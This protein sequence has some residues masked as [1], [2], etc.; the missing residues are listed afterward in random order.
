MDQLADMRVFVRAI[1]R[2]AFALAAKDLGLSPSAVSKLVTRLESRLGVRLVNRT[3]RQ[4]SL[5]ADGEVYFER[6]RQLILALDDLETE[7]AASGGRPRG[8]LRVSGGVTFGLA[9][10]APT[11]V[12][13][14]ERYPE[15]R[16][17]L[18][19]ADRVIDLHKEHIDVAL[20][21]GPQR[22]SSLMTRKIAITRSMLC[23]SPRYL[24]EFGT[25][26]SPDDLAQHRCIIHSGASHADR[27]PFHA[28]D[29]EL[30]QMPVRGP[31]STD[32]S[33]CALRLAL[34]GAGI[35]RLR[36]LTVSAALRSGELV[37]VLRDLH[38]A[39][40][41]TICA[42]FPPGTQKIPRVRAFLDFLV[43][44][45]AGC[46]G[47]CETPQ[48]GPDRPESE[49]APLAPASSCGCGPTR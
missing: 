28:A 9:V 27:W 2:G 47:P 21:A 48:C 37:P 31:I 3:T 42:V 8:V 10:W 7:V 11:I 12:E 35:V 5:T 41:H 30:I 49:L 25:P 15:V 44:R 22:D 46:D 38:H 6:G 36:D 17:E 4:L 1:E 19:L 43:E 40:E 26:N 34:L 33:E 16:V 23:A 14:Q 32:N 18:S 20:R 13:F 29:G 39:E 24:A 45:C